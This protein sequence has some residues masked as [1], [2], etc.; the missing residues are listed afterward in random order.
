MNCRQN[1]MIIP[2][3][4]WF[5]NG[6][7]RNN[8]EEGIDNASKLRKSSKLGC[9][10]RY[11]LRLLWVSGRF[12]CSKNNQGAICFGEPLKIYHGTFSISWFH[13]AVLSKSGQNWAICR[14]VSYAMGLCNKYLKSCFIRTGRV[15]GDQ[16]VPP[17]VSSLF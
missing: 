4:K 7:L 3:E 8:K 1:I 12:N 13:L 2:T 14:L 9:F 17:S 6:K 5:T 10:R 16:L 11:N 15:L